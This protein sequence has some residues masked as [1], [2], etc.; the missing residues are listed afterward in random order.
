[1]PPDSG[2]EPKL[3]PLAD[4]FEELWSEPARWRSYSEPACAYVAHHHTFA[5]TAERLE[6]VYT[7]LL[8]S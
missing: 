4:A 2:A 7:E 3:S 1:M 5:H 6:R 8:S